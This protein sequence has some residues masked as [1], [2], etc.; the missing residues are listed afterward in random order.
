MDTPSPDEAI[1]E[2]PHYETNPDDTETTYTVI[3]LN[4]EKTTY[5][6]G[7]PE[8]KPVTDALRGLLG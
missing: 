2:R 1:P 3:S 5:V 6:L 8:T 4:G 7:K